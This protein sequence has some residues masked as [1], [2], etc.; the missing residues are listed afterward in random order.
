MNGPRL[1][2]ARVAPGPGKI[3]PRTQM[4]AAEFAK[5]VETH[6]YSVLWEHGS[7]CACSNN[8]ET[9]QPHIN[10]PVCRGRGWEYHT[11]QEVRT[12]VDGISQR[13]DGWIAWGDYAP[14]K[15]QFTVRP[16]HRPGRWHRYTLLDCTTAHS[17]VIERAAIGSVDRPSFPIA[18]RPMRLL[19][20]T[21]GGGT[22]LRNLSLTVTYCRLRGADGLPGPV[23]VVGEDFDVTPGGD[24]D[25]SRGQSRSTAPVG[26]QG[27][28]IEY[29][30]HPRF[31]VRDFPYVIRAGQVQFKAPE[32]AH[33]EMAVTVM[34]DIDFLPREG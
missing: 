17:E 30:T 15:A 2:P 19:M 20:P 31:I 3:G 4:T 5:L 9:G 24:I 22:V 27:Y 16:E 26:G 6:G 8:P 33:E 28:A 11:A 34:A 14:G 1:T 25:W 10:C 21:H 23:R 29:E 7:R 18:S 32:A 13:A 12:I